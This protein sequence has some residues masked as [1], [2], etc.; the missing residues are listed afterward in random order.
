MKVVNCLYTFKVQTLTAV[1]LATNYFLIGEAGT[2]KTTFAEKLCAYTRS[3][4]K[5]ALGYTATALAAQVICVLDI[6]HV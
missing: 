2:G 3:K 5:I 1:Y 4:G 6:C